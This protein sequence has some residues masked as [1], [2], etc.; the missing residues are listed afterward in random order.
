MHGFRGFCFGCTEMTVALEVPLTLEESSAESE[1]FIRRGVLME[2]LGTGR[3]KASGP[4]DHHFAN[5]CAGAVGNA[6]VV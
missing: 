1:V 3:D 6:G 5:E 2:K 4:D